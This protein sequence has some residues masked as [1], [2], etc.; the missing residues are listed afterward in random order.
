MGLGL[1]TLILRPLYQ[2][3]FQQRGLDHQQKELEQAAHADALSHGLLP[4]ELAWP[5]LKRSE[6]YINPNSL[7][8]LL[9]LD[10]G[11]N[12]LVTEMRITIWVLVGMAKTLSNLWVRIVLVSEIVCFRAP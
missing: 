4:W 7:I 5:A 8:S 11:L 2:V 9:K 12:K 6:V 3:A 10:S 1:S